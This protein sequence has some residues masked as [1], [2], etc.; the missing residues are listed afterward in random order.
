MLLNEANGLELLKDVANE[1]AICTA[2]VLWH[3]TFPLVAATILTPQC[4]YS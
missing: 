1:A 4:S 2:G 3:D